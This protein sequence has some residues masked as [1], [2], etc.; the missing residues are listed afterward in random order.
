MAKQTPEIAG[1]AGG[2]HF[3]SLPDSDPLCLAF[4]PSISPGR[5]SFIFYC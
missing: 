2:I 1:G 5:L 4:G 3:H